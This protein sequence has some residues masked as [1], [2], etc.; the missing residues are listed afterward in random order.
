VDVFFT[1]GISEFNQ[2]AGVRDWAEQ[3]KK[4]GKIKLFG[5]ALTRTWRIA[6]WLRPSPADRF[7]HVHLQLPLMNAPKMKEAVDAC[8]QAGSA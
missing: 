3:M 2:I 6:C 5:S 7:G 4:A 8:A 1:H